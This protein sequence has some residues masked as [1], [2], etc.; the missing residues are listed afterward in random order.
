MTNEVEILWKELDLD[1]EIN[2]DVVQER[3][4][5]RIT[6]WKMEIRRR[7]RGNNVAIRDPVVSRVHG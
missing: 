6:P 7:S 1:N 4:R 3:G 5:R 2:K